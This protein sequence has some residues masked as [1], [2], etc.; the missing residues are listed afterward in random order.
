MGASALP[1][2][3]NREKIGSENL[4]IGASARVD[5]ATR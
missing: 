5:V 4:I 3:I 1:F 2:G